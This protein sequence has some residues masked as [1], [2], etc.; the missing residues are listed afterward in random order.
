MNRR[1]FLKACLAGAG[2]AAGFGRLS[3][4]STGEK[5]A[6]ETKRKAVLKL[7]SQ[8]GRL[9]GE[10]LKEKVENLQKYGGVGLEIGAGGLPGRI[11][12]IKHALTRTKVVVSAICAAAG[13]YIIPDEGAR[14]K[15]MDSAKMLLS[16]AAELGATGVIMVPAFNGAQDQL[17][18]KPA[19]DLLLR[20]LAE[21]GEH[22]AKAGSRVLIE[23]LNRNE[24]FFL[25]Q[26]ADAASICRDANSPGVAMMGDLYHMYIEETSDMGAFVSAGGYLHHVHMASRTRVL[27]GQDDGSFVDAF[28]GLKM[29]GYRGFCSLEC[30]C[31]GDPAVEIPKSFRF[32]EKQWENA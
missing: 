30:G 22:G 13:P 29:I 16:A 12:E 14:R 17:T 20:V 32:L 4:A 26:L 11:K 7:G 18:G 25:R 31:N 24:A 21:L 3:G 6:E 5:P 10:T 1:G 8:E 28:R 2:A 23:P 19:R 15:A 9:P 27:P